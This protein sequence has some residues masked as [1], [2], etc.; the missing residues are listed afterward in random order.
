M[1]GGTINLAEQPCVFPIGM[2]IKIYSL[3]LFFSLFRV[4]VR[5]CGSVSCLCGSRGGQE[6]ASEPPK[7]ELRGCESLGWSA[8][9]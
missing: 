7:L 6:W 3:S 1:A 8:G 2:A 5:V 4:C 9:N